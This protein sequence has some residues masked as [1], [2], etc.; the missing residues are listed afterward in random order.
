[1]QRLEVSG[2]VR[3]IYGSLGVKGLTEA[4]NKIKYITSK[5]KYNIPYIYNAVIHNFIS[6]YIILITQKTVRLLRKTSLQ[7]LSKKESQ[8]LYPPNKN[9]RQLYFIHF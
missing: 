9:P 8:Q 5:L 2:A 7:L 4:L 3:P 1:M 6:H